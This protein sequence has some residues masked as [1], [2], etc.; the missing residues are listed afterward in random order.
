MDRSRKDTSRHGLLGAIPIFQS[1]ASR[2]VGLSLH[3]A[4][5]LHVPPGH[6][7]LSRFHAYFRDFTEIVVSQVPKGKQI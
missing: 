1:S 3:T 5:G 4:W 2:S 6:P 7:T